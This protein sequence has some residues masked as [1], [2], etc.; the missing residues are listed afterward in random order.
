MSSCK[1]GIPSVLAVT[2]LCVG[3]GH[4]FKPGDI[5]GSYRGTN[6]GIN[7]HGEFQNINWA[8]FEASANGTFTGTIGWEAGGSTPGNAAS[9]GD[10][11]RGDSED[12]LGLFNPNDGTLVLVENV[13]SGTAIGRLRPDGTLEL[14]KTQPGEH[15]VVT[16]ATM[17]REK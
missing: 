11:A 12:V 14:L 15:P 3:C 4:E 8:K 13:E 9:S 7:R 5:T 10:V 17:M 6:L 1:L 16:F 2:L